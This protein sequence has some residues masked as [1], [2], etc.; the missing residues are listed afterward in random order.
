MSIPKNFDPSTVESRIYQEWL[1]RGFFRSTPDE[2][3][4]YTIVIPPPNVTGVLHMGHVLNNT[5]Q[6]VLIRKARMEGK[7]ACWVPG[8]DHASIATEAKVVGQLREEGL[9]KADITR[10]EFLEKAFEWK[11]K[12]AGIILG[13]LKT[14]GASCD[15]DRECFTMEDDL[16]KSVVKV[17]VD[18]FNKGLVYR[19]LK[20]INWD[21]RAKT[22]LSNE[23]VVYK[24]Q[25]SKLFHVKYKLSDS[26]EFLTIATTRPETI[27]GDT[28]IC[29]HPDDERYKH[30]HG[31]TAIVPIANR[32]VPIIPDDYVD[33]EFGTGAL[34][35][36]PAHDPNDYEIGQRHDLEAIDILEADGRLSEKA[37][38]YIGADRFE[39]RKL[40][41][42]DIEKLGQLVKVDTINN[43]VGYS[44]RNPDTVVE[45]RLSLQWFVKM[46]ELSNTALAK[47]L[48][49]E[50]KFFPEKFLNT[51]RHWLENF[52]DWP[53]SR[54]LWWGQQI[55]AW[56]YGDGQFAVAETAEEALE[57]ARKQSG[58]DGL[59]LSD[60]ER[61]PD[62]V[63]TW[64]SSW[65]WPISVFDGFTDPGN[66]EIEYYYPTNV[67]VTGWDIIFFWV[68]RMVMAGYEFKD[69]RPFNEV[70]FTGM[71][72]DSQRR[73]MS[74]SLG[75]SPDTLELIGKF[76]ADGVRFGML[77]SAPAGNDL[78]FDEKL[79]DQ[80]R[81]FTNKIWNVLKL[82]KSWEVDPKGK[83]ENPWIQEWFENLKN[84]KLTEIENSFKDYRLSEA[85]MNT[86]T[87]IWDDFCSWY[88]EWV[89]PEYGSPI[90]AESY[91]QTIS[92]FE[93]LLKI[94]HPFMP[95]VTEEIWHHLRERGVNEYL[96]VSEYPKADD[97]DSNW[98]EQADR[99][100]EIISKIR[101]VRTQNGV[102]QK[103]TVEAQYIAGSGEQF[104]LFE[105]GIFKLGKLEKMD[106]IEEK[107][108]DPQL[109]GFVVKGHQFF[110]NTGQEI[111]VEA[112]RKRLSEE[113]EYTK[114]FIASVEKKLSNDR[115][116]NHAPEQVVD[117]ER[118]K[119]ADG[120]DK[121]NALE[122][123]LSRL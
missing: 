109:Q 2:R 91:E 57:I 108:D 53:I 36:T 25:D 4:P 49:G 111:D 54:Q 90:D 69:E 101:E 39:A 52:R 86:Y 95:F 35:V 117:K 61:D 63:D 22:T 30:L 37:G 21:P 75:N 123:S 32:E 99:A 89:K 29:V 47:V 8:T 110:I 70:Y 42:D 5:I 7:N 81:N 17:F 93:E 50:I 100:K 34:K 45:S 79:C 94:L 121:L 31:K 19:D 115:F 103:D 118:K 65:L 73:K 3:E 23:E 38:H 104:D 122:E 77:A 43:K 78:L 40:I 76:G 41:I 44:E 20:M 71:V 107:P 15:W 84:S 74:K 85:L 27:L 82:I 59:Q 72:R 96:V 56:Y 64:F 62:V 24:E 6:D 1:D 11:E 113:I 55:P 83:N 48:E 9:T 68:A 98:L 67:L 116:V 13:Q 10:E 51:Y 92:I 112:E 58:N 114:G 16:N 97:F 28:A 46:E 120:Q 87:F 80:G 60:L 66:E 26:N 14:L 119:L 33:L 12:Y 88:L 105:T 102:K 18:L 106:K